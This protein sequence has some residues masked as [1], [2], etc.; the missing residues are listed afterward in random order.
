MTILPK[1]TQG[2]KGMTRSWHAQGG[3]PPSLDSAK[4][5]TKS[6]LGSPRKGLTSLGSR[7]GKMLSLHSV[8]YI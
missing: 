5:R 7:L 3:D 4:R 2:N 6:P 1:H 8:Y